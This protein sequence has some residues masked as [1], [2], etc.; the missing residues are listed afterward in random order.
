MTTSR[1]GFTLIELLVVI[2]IIAVLI[3]L[4]LPAVQKVRAA[5]SRLRCS[6]NLKQIGLAAHAAHDAHGSFPGGMGWYPG[7]GAYGPFLF[8]LLPFVEQ[9]ALYQNSAYAGFFFVGNNQTFSR[10][11]AVYICPS[12]PSAPPDG[13][14]KDMFGNMWGVS[15]YAVNSQVVAPTDPTG[16]LLGPDYRARLE[17]DFPDGTSSTILLTEKYAQCSNDNY[18]VGGNFWGYYLTDSN[19]LFPYHAGYA[20]SWNGYSIGPT[21]KFQ[22]RP[23]PFNGN[24]DPTLASSPHSGGI[25]A[26][27]VD[28]SVRFLSASV[29]NFTW[30]YLTTPHGGEVVPAD[31]Q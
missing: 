5:A 18:P 13:R 10:P 9:Q 17:A 20:I 19:T 11:V 23:D 7:Q 16:Q 1:R 22:T 8:H 30:W 31:A 12:D 26:C 27:M 29:T 14:G 28:G 21:S 24:C 2:G 3:G 4:L 25:N 6:N 15:G